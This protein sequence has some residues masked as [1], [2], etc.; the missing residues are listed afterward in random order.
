MIDIDNS[1]DDVD[2]GYPHKVSLVWSN[3]NSEA[4]AWLRE[5]CPD[6]YYVESV[7]FPENTN[8][9]NVRLAFRDEDDAVAF[10]LIFG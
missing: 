8:H 2:G 6:D 9:K 4:S 1:S 10:K 3:G 5:H 7:V